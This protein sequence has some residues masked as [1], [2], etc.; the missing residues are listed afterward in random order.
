[1]ACREGFP[2]GRTGVPQ[3]ASFDMVASSGGGRLSTPHR[4]RKRRWS[5]YCSGRG[6]SP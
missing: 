6:A 3:D 5:S 1:M 4:V 2:S